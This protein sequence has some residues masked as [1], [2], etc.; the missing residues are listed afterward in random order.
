[1]ESEVSKLDTQTDNKINYRHQHN[2]SQT[3]GSMED[4]DSENDPQEKD[5][6]ICNILLKS[7]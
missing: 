2:Q 4:L 7:I 5:F 1:M 3:Q 6:I